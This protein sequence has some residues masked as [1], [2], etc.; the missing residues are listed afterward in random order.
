MLWGLNN[1]LATLVGVLFLLGTFDKNTSALKQVMQSC[2]ACKSLQLEPTKAWRQLDWLRR[3]SSASPWSSACF[4]WIALPLVYAIVVAFLV[5]MS[6]PETRE[7]HSS[8]LVMSV[9]AC[10]GAVVRL[11]QI[12]RSAV[13]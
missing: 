8:L 10:L 2:E 7:D 13:K 1:A 5:L 3:L 6:N 4:L 11:F 9:F 12:C